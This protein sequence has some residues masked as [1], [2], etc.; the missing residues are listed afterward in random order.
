MII[1]LFVFF[2]FTFFLWHSLL[3]L[4]SYCQPILSYCQ[5]ILSYCQPILSYCQPIYAFGARIS[6][7]NI[8]FPPQPQKMYSVKCIYNICLLLLLPFFFVFDFGSM[9]RQDYFTR[10]SLGGAKMG[11]SPRKTTIPPA[12][13]T[14]FI[15]R[16][17]S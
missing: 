8:N 10:Q 7:K 4:L 1:F 11:D 9:A 2:L 12:S 13:R 15:S 16:D 5:P 14:W 3:L 17:L 6:Q